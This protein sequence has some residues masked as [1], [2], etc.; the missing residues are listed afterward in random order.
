M[1]TETAPPLRDSD[2]LG[3]ARGRGSAHRLDLDTITHRRVVVLD[4]YAVYRYC[5]HTDFFGQTAAA[6]YVS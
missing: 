1:R 2:G 4:T 3:F 6:S 5:I